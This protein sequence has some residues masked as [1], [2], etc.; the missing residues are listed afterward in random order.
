V[1]GSQTLRVDVRV[2]AATNKDLAAEIRAGRF[3]EDLFFRLNVVPVH[4]PPLRERRDDIPLLAEHFLSAYLDENGL[5]ARQFTPEALQLLRTLPWP[6]N[7]R[8]LSNAVERLAIL[9]RGPRIG[10]DDLLRHGI[11]VDLAAAGQAAAPRG[12]AAGGDDLEIPA[13]VMRAGGLVAARQEFE[14]RCILAALTEAAGN[15]SQAAR[16]LGIDRT[17]LHKKIQT[18]GLGSGREG[19]N[20]P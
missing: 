10:P 3:R 5:P 20:D 17:N 14:K 1:G 2:L 7:I 16:L 12:T 15:V 6:G 18:Y 9:T 19:G 13:A 4:V 8:E 11:G